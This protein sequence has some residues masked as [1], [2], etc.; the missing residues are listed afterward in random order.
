MKSAADATGL[1]QI[2]LIATDLDGTLLN[3]GHALSARNAA[4]LKRAQEAGLVVVLVTGRPIR[5]VLPLARELGLHGHVICT[6]G[7]ATHRLPGGEREDAQGIPA[8]V[9]RGVVPRLRQGIAGVGFALEYGDR[10]VRET[11]LRD[12]TES[13]PDI[14]D[15]LN[16]EVALKLI[17]R[18]PGHETHAL[19]AVINALCAGELEATSSGASFSEVAAWGVNKGYALSR[20]Y[21]SLGLEAGQCLAF[22]DAHN[23]LP[24][25]GC[26][27]TAVAMGNAPA[28][29]KQAASR[30]TASNDE[31][32]VALVIEA[33]L[34]AR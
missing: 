1:G 13:V 23:D 8:E 25:F 10:V 6:N 4:A 17:V 21:R 33:L 18:S 19:N 12:D 7:A 27:G 30:V 26:V 9:L 11:G 16:N 5:M 28:D 31:D 22:G 14:L 29:L 20:L 34:E 2:A 32:G 24:M 15:A 3:T